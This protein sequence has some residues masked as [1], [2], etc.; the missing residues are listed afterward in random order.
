MSS[1]AAMQLLLLAHTGSDHNFMF[2]STIMPKEKYFVCLHIFPDQRANI[3]HLGQ[4]QHTCTQYGTLLA[5]DVIWLHTI[6]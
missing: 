1:S 3:A 5:F 4:I 6:R 2:N